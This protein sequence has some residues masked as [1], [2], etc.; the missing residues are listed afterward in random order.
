MKRL[1]VG[2][3]VT[4]VE[5][6]AAAMRRHP[7][8]A[9]K[10]FTETERRRAGAKPERFATRWAAKEAV[11]KLYGEAGLRIPHYRSD[12]GGQPAAGEPRRS[13]WPAA[14]PGSRSA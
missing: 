5:R 2:V 10:I 13:G 4:S 8:F 14:P 6:I 11:M 7:R 9:E 3:D 1:A 12:R